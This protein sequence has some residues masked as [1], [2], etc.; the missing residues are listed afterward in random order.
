MLPPSVTSTAGLAQLVR[1][2][3]TRLQS[4]VF[5]FWRGWLRSG[6]SAVRPCSRP[7]SGTHV[8]G[9]SPCP[10]DRARAGPSAPSHTPRAQRARRLRASRHALRHAP[11]DPRR[12]NS[13]PLAPPHATPPGRREGGDSTPLAPP[14]RLKPRP[15]D[16]VNAPQH[17]RRDSDFP[18]QAS[19]PWSTCAG[20]PSGRRFVCFGI[21]IILRW[22]RLDF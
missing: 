4:W 20:R 21:I 3:K 22:F 6:T 19:T 13:R 10:G 1:P 8:L 5:G 2:I 11:R 15:S 16:A 18:P 17:F 14:L 9:D 12:G 7:A